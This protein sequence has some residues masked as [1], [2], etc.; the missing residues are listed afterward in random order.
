MKIKRIL[1]LG[2]C[3]IN[4]TL[5][6]LIASSCI[7]KNENEKD[8]SNKDNHKQTKIEQTVINFSDPSGNVL[9]TFILKNISNNLLEE[10]KVLVP[11]NYLLPQSVT[12]EQ[13]K[14]NEINDIKL[15]QTKVSDE[16]WNQYIQLK[17]Q[18]ETLLKENEN[19]QIIAKRISYL[20]SLLSD[21]PSENKDLEDIRIRNYLF[22]FQR[23]LNIDDDLIKHYQ[24]KFKHLNNL[25]SQILTFLDSLLNKLTDSENKNNLSNLKNLLLNWK[26]YNL[27]SPYWENELNFL[28]GSFVNLFK[29]WFNTLEQTTETQ[30]NIKQ[31]NEYLSGLNALTL[32]IIKAGDENDPINFNPYLFNE[33]FENI[34]NF[35]SNDLLNLEI[36]TIKNELSTFNNVFANKLASLN[37]EFNSKKDFYADKYLLTFNEF[38]DIKDQDLRTF[39]TL[40]SIINNLNNQYLNLVVE[41]DKL[42]AKFSLLNFYNQKFDQISFDNKYQELKNQ[43]ANL[44]NKFKND[45]LKIIHTNLIS[46]INNVYNNYLDKDNKN[47]QEN[48]TQIN[49]I[50]Q[51]LKKL[52]L[53]ENNAFV[54]LVNLFN[55][56]YDVIL[57]ILES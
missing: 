14:V 30:T 36:K 9:N 20:K 18:I 42:I 17:T 27:N 29:Y 4:A 47:V 15:I 13:L 55:N 57:N 8:S 31:F 39:K 50:L 43:L 46:E 7:Q 45:N 53:E 26:D 23:E 34:I 37:N 56:Y 16:L 21:A 22:S 25:T 5:P 24:N 38:I 12:N 32:R 41:I 11:Q 33:L 54:N 40:T 49:D 28:F 10:I 48:L 44:I 1:C 3:I 2:T 51:N 19:N 35:W 52:N 6:I